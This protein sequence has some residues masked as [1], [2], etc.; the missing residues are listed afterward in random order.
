MTIESRCCQIDLYEAKNIMW[1]FVVANAEYICLFVYKK[2]MYTYK[3]L[4]TKYWKYRNIPWLLNPGVAKLSYTK[5]EISLL[6]GLV[7]TDY[8]LY[9]DTNDIWPVL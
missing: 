3:S 6:H 7:V 5:R 8:N 2:A 9:I 1:Q 4:W